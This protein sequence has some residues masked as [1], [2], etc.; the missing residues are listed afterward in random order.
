MNNETA[1]RELTAQELDLVSGG[2]IN[3]GPFRFYYSEGARA[4]GVVSSDATD[5]ERSRAFCA[6]RDRHEEAKRFLASRRQ[7]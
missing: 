1:G 7:P 6:Y 4:F 2:D 3:L 5:L